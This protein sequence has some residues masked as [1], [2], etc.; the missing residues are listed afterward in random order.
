M[1]DEDKNEQ[2]TSPAPDSTQPAP[3][4]SV[5]DRLISGLASVEITDENTSVSLKR[6][7][8]KTEIR[9]ADDGAYIEREGVQVAGFKGD[10]QAGYFSDNLNNHPLSEARLTS[11]D[12]FLPNS[13]T[14]SRFAV[15]Y[16]GTR[17]VGSGDTI[18][19]ASDVGFQN[20]A[21]GAH[22]G[23]EYTT[24]A[25]RFDR[26]SS[27]GVVARDVDFTVGADAVA[28][29]N[30]VGASVYGA[31]RY[32]QGNLAATAQAQILVNPGAFD[33]RRQSFGS[34]PDVVAAVSGDVAYSTGPNRLTGYFQGAVGTDGHRLEIGVRQPGL[35]KI[36][37][38]PMA[39]EA[40]VGQD[41][42]GLG[43][44]KDGLGYRADLGGG[45]MYVRAG[46]KA[47]F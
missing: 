35:I 40:G 45:G 3:E 9:V 47:D 46:L 12:D 23:A 16:E 17:K 14:G 22:V 25:K 15:S 4:K 26:P 7:D 36:A 38:L 20:G 33:L 24:E 2:A 31:A 27:E 13:Q 30:G 39:G 10:V 5:V 32:T 6:I 11:R 44:G 21:L 18:A 8:P 41:S 28:G 42:R 43:S 34:R 37:G 29:R 1:G 19:I